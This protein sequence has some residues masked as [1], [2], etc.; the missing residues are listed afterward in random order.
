MKEEHL[1]EINQEIIDVSQ[2]VSMAYHK[3]YIK[4]YDEGKKKAVKI[5]DDREKDI[6]KDAY[7][8]GLHDA[9]E[10][11]RKITLLEEDGGY[12]QN[13]INVWFFRSGY[14]VLKE[15]DAS[16]VIGSLKRLEQDKN[17]ED[18]KVGDEVVEKGDNRKGVIVCQDNNIWNTVLFCDGAHHCF[19]KD[20]IEK[21]GRHFDQMVEIFK[22]MQEAE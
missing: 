9:W 19:I 20:N 10:A 14:Y 5:D 1:E 15:M 11:A 18:L 6:E 13:K 17:D 2:I 3:G 16:E 7:A 4:G 12:N 22:Q 21:T 8:R